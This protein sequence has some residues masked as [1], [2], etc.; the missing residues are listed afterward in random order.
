MRFSLVSKL[1]QCV[2]AGKRV[3]NQLSFLTT[4][5]GSTLL[6]GVNSSAFGPIPSSAHLSGD[7]GRAHITFATLHLAEGQA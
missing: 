6:V 4:Q 5:S 1:S 2:R 3:F 7:V